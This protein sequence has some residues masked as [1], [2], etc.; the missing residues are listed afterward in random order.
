[1]APMTTSSDHLTER[2]FLWIA[3][4]PVLRGKFQ[5]AKAMRKHVLSKQTNDDNNNEIEAQSFFK[6][7]IYLK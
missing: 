1:M 4:Q 3:D 5:P 2:K 7:C 6:R